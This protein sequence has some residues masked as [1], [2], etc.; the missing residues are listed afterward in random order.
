MKRLLSRIAAAWRQLNEP[1]APQCH[2][3]RL[4][5][6]RVIL[7]VGAELCADCSRLTPEEWARFDR[8][9]SMPQMAHG[10]DRH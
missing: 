9:Q 4:S 8:Q 7:A 10:D 6:P 2:Q 1:P 5:P 3:C